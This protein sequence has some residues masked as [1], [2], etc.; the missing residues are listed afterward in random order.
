MVTCHI[1][2]LPERELSLQKTIFSVYNQVDKIYVALNGHPSIPRWLDS[3]PK[4][5]YEVL[6]NSLGDSAR[7]LHVNDDK[8]LCFILDDDLSVCPT[9][10]AYLA[11]GVKRYD[12]VVS[13]HGRKY[14]APVRSFKQW[15][16]NYRCLGTVSEDVKVTV[17]GD[18]CCAFDNERLKVHISDFKM[19]NMANLFLSKIA[20]QQ[21]IPM[22]VLKHGAD[23]LEY[24]PPKDNKTI[25]R[26]TSNYD[27]Q[28]ELLKSFIK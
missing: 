6:D 19:R 4:V 2:S 23:W 8:G 13:L 11:Q 16:G 25:W 5:S 10:C 26:T 27:Y 24:T 20:T 21:G 7:Y 22:M 17:I 18:G 3:M 1:A 28:T 14:F 15:A 9:Y 12:G